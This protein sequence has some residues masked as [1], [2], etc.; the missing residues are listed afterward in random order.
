MARKK[1]HHYL[2]RFYLGGFVDPLHK[3]YVWI[4][5]K[6]DSNITRSTPRNIAVR[7]H[8]YS[9]ETKSGSID[10]QS[11]ENALADVENKA[12]PVFQKVLRHEQ[13]DDEDRNAFAVFLS[14]MT[15]RVPNYRENLESVFGKLAKKINRMKE[16]L[17]MIPH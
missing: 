13:L 3:P 14:L 7:K 6:G 1:R 16:V 8:Y 17:K 2:P 9:F 4:Y 5:E 15:A 10:S 11:V 12:A